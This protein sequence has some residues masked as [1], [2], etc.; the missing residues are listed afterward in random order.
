M[1]DHFSLCATDVSGKAGA[2]LMERLGNFH[3]LRVVGAQPPLGQMWSSPSLLVLVVVFCPL[4]PQLVR[5]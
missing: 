3:M 1:T 2:D 4:R 5:L